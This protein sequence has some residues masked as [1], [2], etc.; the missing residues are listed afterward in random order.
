M[1]LENQVALVTGAASDIGYAY[2]KRLLLNKVKVGKSKKLT[3]YIYISCSVFHI[4]HIL[5]SYSY[6]SI[7]IKNITI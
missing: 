2:V 4:I 5:L 6:Y 1:G 3:N 7:H